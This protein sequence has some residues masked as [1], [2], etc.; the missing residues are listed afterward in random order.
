MKKINICDEYINEFKSKLSK[1][2][3]SNIMDTLYE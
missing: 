2:L 1:I 3:T